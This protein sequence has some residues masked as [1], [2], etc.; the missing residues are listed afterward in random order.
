MEKIGSVEKGKLGE[1]YVFQKIIE[2]GAMPFTPIADIHGIDA[3]IRKKDGTYVDIQIKTSRTEWSAGWWDIWGL[4]PRDNL[5]FVGVMMTKE[6]PEVWI[7]PSKV[8]EQYATKITSKGYTFYR[9]GLD[10][11]KR[12]YGQELQDKLRE[13]CGAWHLLTG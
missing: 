4:I 3:V 10:S 2:N 12:K 5:F 8:Y 1:L 9:L 13:Y 7:F 6:P 11:G